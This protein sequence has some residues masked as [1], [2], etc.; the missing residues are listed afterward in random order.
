MQRK[1]YSH[2]LEYDPKFILVALQHP[3]EAPCTWNGKNFRGSAK[4]MQTKYV[5][6]I[7]ASRNEIS[8]FTRIKSIRFLSNV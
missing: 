8:N 4:S 2:G 1:S 7:K 5:S 6:S 3:H